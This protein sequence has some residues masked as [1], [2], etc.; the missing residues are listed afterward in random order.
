MSWTQET[1]HDAVEAQRAYFRSGETLPVAWRIEQLKKLK[2]AVL[3]REEQLCA[4]LGLSDRFGEILGKRK[5][6]H[7]G[8]GRETD[9][10]D[11]DPGEES[12]L[13]RDSGE[14]T[15][16]EETVREVKGM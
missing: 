8:T 4:A 15:V 3:D 12:S 6:E 11:G 7:G 1:I 9:A 16:L 10:S 14:E 2:Q 13:F 5:A